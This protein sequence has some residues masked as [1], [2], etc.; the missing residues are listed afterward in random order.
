MENLIQRR[1]A[2]WVGVGG[3][4]LVMA[5]FVALGSIGWPGNGDL[6]LAQVPNTCFCEQ[7]DPHGIVKQ[8]VNTWSNIGFIAAGLLILWQLG[9]TRS[10]AAGSSN[11]MVGP[12]PYSIG[13]GML[14]VF[15]GPASMFFHGSL[16]DWGGWLD[17][18]SLILYGSFLLLYDVIRI[19]RAGT[20]VFAGLYLMLV[21][22]LALVTWLVK[23]SGQVVFGILILLV[24]SSQIAILTKQVDGVRREWMPW[25]LV[26]LLCFG[27][28]FFGIW[29]WSNTAGPLC[30]PESWLQGHALWHL[31]TAASAFFMYLYLRTEA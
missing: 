10:P 9:T 25:L 2:F 26:S 31:L 11:P 3:L 24:L 17:I 14:V 20:E 8:P 18:L 21:G 7:L 29:L 4:T 28:A 1:K 13:Y 19:R 15:L 6:C 30:T 16:R 23:N 22:P 27:T 5:A 12:T